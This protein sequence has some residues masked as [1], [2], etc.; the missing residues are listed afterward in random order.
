VARAL[1]S[2]DHDVKIGKVDLVHVERYE[3]E[4]AYEGADRWRILGSRPGTVDVAF[5]SHCHPQDKSRLTEV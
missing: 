2:A 4:N 5:D 3:C 1:I